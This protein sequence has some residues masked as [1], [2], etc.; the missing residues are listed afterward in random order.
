MATK[1]FVPLAF[2]LGEVFQFDWSE[3]GIVIAGVYRG[4]QVAHIKLCASRAL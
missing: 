1:A 3:E 4:L 2:E